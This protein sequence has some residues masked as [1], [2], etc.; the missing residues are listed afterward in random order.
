MI[1]FRIINTKTGEEVEIDYY[2]VVDN[3]GNPFE[4]LSGTKDIE[5]MEDGIKVQFGFELN[6][7]Q[8][9]EG[10]VLTDGLGCISYIVFLDGQFICKSPNQFIKY[11]NLS[12]VVEYGGIVV[13]N[14]YQEELW[15]YLRDY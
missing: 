3:K 4:I 2:A 8:Y 7:K 5:Y 12:K 13:G 14:I 11:I 10:D 1:T 6:G 15:I 9:F